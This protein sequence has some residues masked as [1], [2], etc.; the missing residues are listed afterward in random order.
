MK[1]FTIDREM[2]VTAYASQKAANIVDTGLVVTSAEDL[3]AALRT[4]SIKP[5]DLWNSLPGVTPTAKM[6][7]RPAGIKRIWKRL[8]TLEVTPVEE[9]TPAKKARKAKASNGAETA[10][11]P[12]DGSKQ[13]Q[14]VDLLKRPEGA[15]IEL[16]MNETGWQRHTVRGFIAGA[17]KNKLGLKIES[18]KENDC[19]TYRVIA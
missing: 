18:F 15:T 6:T 4:L 16:I 3:D 7:N 12:R 2:N 9:P 10:H 13:A 5:T 11:T 19:R 14:V 8:D 1:T 17:A